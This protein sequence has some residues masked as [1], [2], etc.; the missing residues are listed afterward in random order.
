M[1]F[2]MQAE[3]VEAKVEGTPKNKSN[4][5]SI[6][7]AN[8]DALVRGPPRVQSNGGGLESYR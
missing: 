7:S 6:F 1:R 4:L 2:A 5:L 8:F 3:R